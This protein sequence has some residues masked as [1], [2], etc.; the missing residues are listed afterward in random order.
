[1][2]RTL[3]IAI[4][5]ILIATLPALAGAIKVWAS[6]DTLTSADLNANFSHIHNSMVGGHGARLVD[7]DVSNTAN[8]ATAKLAAYRFIPR[9]WGSV[10]SGCSGATC[11]INESGGITSVVAS[12]NQMN[13]TLNYT[14]T[15]ALYAVIVS[16]NS[17]TAGVS[18]QGFPVST[19]VFRIQCNQHQD[20]T[21][22]IAAADPNCDHV[23]LTTFPEV[24]FMILDGD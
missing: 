23:F 20:P 21:N 7:A 2:K 19:T 12:A 17:T 6:G 10:Q 8:I 15:D 1:M 3:Q 13:V 14:A 11:T 18:C 5:S 4:V 16:S 22:C 24:S 9:A